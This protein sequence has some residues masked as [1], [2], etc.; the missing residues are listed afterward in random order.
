MAKTVSNRSVLKTDGALY[1]HIPRLLLAWSD[2]EQ[3]T[4]NE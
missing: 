2:R 3:E 1:T 4:C